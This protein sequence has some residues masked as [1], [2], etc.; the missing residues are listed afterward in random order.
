MRSNNGT[1][2]I[3]LAVA[4]IC[5]GADTVPF[6]APEIVAA[7]TAVAK[8]CSW[9]SD[10]EAAKAIAASEGKD[11]LLLFSSDSSSACNVF[12][13]EA[14]QTPEFDAALGPLFVFV[15]ADLSKCKASLPAATVEQNKE[16]SAKFGLRGLPTLLLLDPQ[17]K[18]YGWM[19]Y[20]P[21]GTTNYIELLGN[22]RK[23]RIK[24]DAA[25]AKAEKAEGIEK[26]K[27]LAEGL[28][29]LDDDVVAQYHG[30]SLAEIAK[31]DPND[32]CGINKKLE[33]K[34]QLAEVEKV[35]RSTCSGTQGVAKAELL[36]DDFISSKKLAGENLQKAMMVKLNF[37][38]PSSLENIEKAL[39][40]VEAVAAIN[41][42][43]STGLI[44]ERI[45]R[46]AEAM[47][48]RMERRP[49]GGQGQDGPRPERPAGPKGP[50][51]PR[52]SLGPMGTNAAPAAFGGK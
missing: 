11:L 41:A 27:L 15:E 19:G 1:A 21:G 10:F 33:F 16:L 34:V 5:S 44:A 4:G 12:K 25:W 17:S 39:K 13:R 26:A 2:V 14:G 37:H 22:L 47:K 52:G 7:T 42:T 9:P 36:M 49:A 20:K 24:R 40:L 31:L 51:G 30:D 43:N 45:K 38:P 32:S 3:L 35:I 29:A 28:S 6:P 23:A 50:M 46:Q 8:V 48:K 18:P